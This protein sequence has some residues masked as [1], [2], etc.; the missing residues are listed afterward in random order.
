[1]TRIS[2]FGQQQ[3][4]LQGITT[5]Q[6]R[7][8]EAQR[9]ITTGKKAEDFQGL[10]GETSTVLGAKSFNSR[11]ETYQQT[12]AT[13]RGKLDAN[14]LQLDGML[15]SMRS[16]QD[17]IRISLANNQSDGFD[18]VLNQTFQFVN[19]SLNTNFGGT[20]LFSGAN[21]G[22]PPVNV[23]N[24]DELLALTAP[25]P[26]AVAA[27][28]SDAFDNSSVSFKARIA[29][30][31]DVDFGLLAS[32]AGTEIYQVMNDLYDYHT[33]TTAIDGELAQPEWN[34]LQTQLGKL[35]TAIDN[36]QQIQVNNGLSYERLDVVDE[37]HK[38]TAVFL[39][40]FISS[41]EDVDIAQA[42]TN[43]NNDQLA[44]EASYRSIGSMSRM[45]LLDFI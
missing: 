5:N 14:D 4:L 38:D 23:D 15:T 20:Y 18:G 11:V 34:F 16:L 31:V 28:V 2:S 25:T 22:T 33:N 40:T 42:I 1:M 19:G 24:L 35:D 45:S 43:L 3:L 10:A 17:T 8:F 12:I 13:V 6:S 30:S 39:E 29:D 44:L 41:I 27:P 37:Q 32:D 9:Q 36:L 7:V 21:T 26:P